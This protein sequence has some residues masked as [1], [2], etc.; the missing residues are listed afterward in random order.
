VIEDK[1]AEGNESV[2]L[3]SESTIRMKIADIYRAMSRGICSK[4]QLQA[5][6]EMVTE[7]ARILEKGVTLE[8]VKA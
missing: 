3:D 2:A 7:A 6:C 4:E 5:A 1:E 8:S